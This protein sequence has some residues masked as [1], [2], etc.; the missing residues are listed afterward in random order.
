MQKKNCIF[1]FIFFHSHLLFKLFIPFAPFFNN[2]KLAK[3]KMEGAFIIHYNIFIHIFIFPTN[4]DGNLFL[5]NVK[6]HAVCAA[7]NVNTYYARQDVR[8]MG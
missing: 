5:S 4:Y 2:S 6:C 3:A 1:L 7:G 8:K